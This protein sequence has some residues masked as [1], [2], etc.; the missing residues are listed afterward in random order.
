M[1][2]IAL[3][4]ASLKKVN[5]SWPIMRYTGKFEMPCPRMAANRVENTA[6]ITIFIKRG[7][8]NAPQYTQHAAA[9]FQLEIPPDQ[10]LQKVAVA[11]EI[12]TVS[13]KHRHAAHHFSKKEKI[14]CGKTGVKLYPLH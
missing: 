9:V 7:V 2:D 8:Q 14:L 5:R 12:L 11:P 4:V 1:L 13:L 10:V 6:T 3:E